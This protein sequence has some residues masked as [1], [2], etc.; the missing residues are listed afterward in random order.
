MCTMF[1]QVNLYILFAQVSIIVTEG[2]QMP[3]SAIWGTS[4]NF[5]STFDATLTSIDERKRQSMIISSAKC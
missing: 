3:D 4:L 5:P 1:A 2:Y